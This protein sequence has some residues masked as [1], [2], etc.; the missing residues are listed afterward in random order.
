MIRFP[1][2]DV[3]REP[4][5]VFRGFERLSGVCN[6]CGGCAD[7]CVLELEEGNDQSVV[8]DMRLENFP[9]AGAPNGR[10]SWV[11]SH[12]RLNGGWG[13]K[14]VDGP[15]MMTKVRSGLLMVMFGM[16]VWLLSE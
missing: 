1:D 2:D 5:Q 15:N 10:G 8:L 11:R 4:G 13:I 6:R 12:D 14:Q 7:C 3:S 16:A 9:G